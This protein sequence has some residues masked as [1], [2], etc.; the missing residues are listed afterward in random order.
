MYVLKNIPNEKSIQDRRSQALFAKGLLWELYQENTDINKFVDENIEYLNGKTDDPESLNDLDQ[1]LSQQIFRLSYWKVG[2]EELNYRRFFTVNE[3][4]SVK[5]EDEKVFNKTHDL[6]FK[7]VRSGKFTGLRIDH[8]DGLYNPLQYLQ[9]IREKVGNVYLTVEKILEIE[10]ELP[11]AWPIEGTS[12]YEFLIY[13]NSLFCQGKNEDRFSQIYRD[14]TGLTASFKQLLIAK[15]RLIADRNLAGD[16]DNLAGLL[17]RIAGQY[18]YGRDLTL[19]G[20]QTAN[21]R[22][23]SSL[24]RL[25]NLY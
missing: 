12:G 4:I 1:L 18:R 13:V 14:A 9:S 3:L 2:A 5:V 23:I 22:S 11:S 17:K 10:E 20:L 15:K 25:S 7:L 8:I 6:I 21:F 16:A 19:H 24:S